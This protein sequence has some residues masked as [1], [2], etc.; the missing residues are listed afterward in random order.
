MTSSVNER[1]LAAVLPLFR[2][3]LGGVEARPGHDAIGLLL[4]GV[5]FGLIQDGVILFRVDARTRPAYD[6]AEA[7][8]AEDGDAVEVDDGH[9][10]WNGMAEPSIGG[11]SASLGFRRLPPFVLDDEDTLADWGKAAWEAAKR[12]RAGARIV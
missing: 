6:A 9:G 7:S 1:T 8:T 10:P 12:A 3:A 11:A 2:A 5:L 4:Q